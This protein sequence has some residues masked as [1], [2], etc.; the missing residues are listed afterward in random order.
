M[1]TVLRAADSADFLRIVPSLAGFT[2]RRSILLLPFRG[3]RTHG[4][5]R[6]DLPADHVDPEGYADAAI[7]LVTRVDG[8]DAVAVVAYVDDEP[9]STHDG[10]LLPFA[11]QVDDLLACADERDLRI[12]DALCVTPA[13]WA[14]YLHDD[15]QLVPFDEVPPPEVP[16]GADVS[17]DQLSGAAL[18]TADLAEKERVGRAL[19]DISGLLDRGDDVR[20]TA[21]ENPQALAALLL[22]DDVT[23]LFE[24]LLDD[25]DAPPPFAAAAL[26]WCL[27]R[28]LLRDVALTQWASD[29]V[30]GARTLAAQLAFADDGTSIPEDLGELFLGRGPA[31]DADRLRRALRLAR[32]V[33]ARAPRPSRP[34]ALTVAAWLSWALGRASHAAYYLDLVAEI[35]PRYGLAALLRTMIDAAML[36]EWAF[37]R[38]AAA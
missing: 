36:P 7:D 16:G 10:L 17:G 13:G 22:L 30:G 31:P 24:A 38:G 18:P 6:L 35:D 25:P 11:P 27:D 33:A 3:S 19:R 26:L 1:T 34:G 32:A 37:H 15:P 29:R 21:R 14:S 8:T 2:P 12:V 20:L 5:L 9:L 23:E 28:P 4:A